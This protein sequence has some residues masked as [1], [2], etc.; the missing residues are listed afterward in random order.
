MGTVKAI[1][2]HFSKLVIPI[3]RGTIGMLRSLSDLFSFQSNVVAEVRFA[4]LHRQTN[5]FLVCFGSA[6]WDYVAVL[7][8]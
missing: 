7:S 5:H 8:V 1:G 4:R 6:C 3:R 2:Q